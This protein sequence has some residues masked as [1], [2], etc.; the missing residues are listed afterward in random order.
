MSDYHTD[1]L[2]SPKFY[3]RKPPE[4]VAAEIFAITPILD[5]THTV[6]LFVRHE[7]ATFDGPRVRVKLTPAQAE[8]LAGEL[9]ERA[10]RA[11][12]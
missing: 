2:A 3:K 7:N 11:R 12:Q 1:C 6:Y 5:D 9:L 10:R 8:A 4:E